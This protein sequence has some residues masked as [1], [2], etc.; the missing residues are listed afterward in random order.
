[1]A[2]LL[3][4]DAPLPQEDALVR[5]PRQGMAKDPLAWRMSD[6]Y[7]GFFT[8][9]S[10]NVNLA[11]ARINN[12]AEVDFSS[13][14]PLTD[15]SGGAL[16]SGLYE[17]RSWV[18]LVA[19]AGVTSSLVLTFSWTY[20]GVSHTAS[21]TVLSTDIVSENASL[22]VP[23]FFSDANSPIQVSTTYA[24]NPPATMAYDIYVALLRVQA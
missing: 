6:S 11:P 13:S 7:I 17:L 2:Q 20:R 9:M 21:A 15:L 1:M 4:E 8:R 18:T 23:M 19:A 14:I 22:G 5:L 24:S 10:T 12:F 16:S 3:L